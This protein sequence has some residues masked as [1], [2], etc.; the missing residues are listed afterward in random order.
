[1]VRYEKPE[2]KI[3][4]IERLP[5]EPQLKKARYHIELSQSEREWLYAGTTL[6]VVSFAAS[7]YLFL[8]SPI[9]PLYDVN[10]IPA[11][12]GARLFVSSVLGI[13]LG[14]LGTALGK[15]F[16]EWLSKHLKKY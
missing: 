10:G 16:A 14:T 7:T 15:G 9:I 12:P 4:E 11:D 6:G 1:M 8:N 2:K 13:M 5:A 3:K